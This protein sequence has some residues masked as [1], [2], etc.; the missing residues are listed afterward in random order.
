[1]SIDVSAVPDRPGGAGRYVV[2]LVRALGRRDDIDLVLVARI[3]DGGR[4][5]ALAPRAEVVAEAPVRRPA[6]L[7]WEQTALAGR[8]RRRRVDVHHGPHYTM[9]ERASLP[10]VVTIHDCT[11]F[12]H[13]EWHERSKVLVF[14]RAIR[15]AAARADALV[16]VSRVTADRVQELC[17]PRAAVH[18]V[19]HGVDHSRF[20]PAEPSPGADAARLHA[21]GLVDPYVAFVGTIEPRKDVP[22]LILAFDR[23]AGEHSGLRLVLAGGAGWGGAA[24]DVDARIAA[25]PHRDRITCT[26]YLPEEDLPALLRGAAVVA[27]PSREEGFGLPAL[28]ALAC[29][30]PVVTTAGSVMAELTAGAATVVPPGDAAAL[31]DALAAQLRS[32]ADAAAGLAVARSYTWEAT[33]DAHALVYRGLAGR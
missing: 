22:S 20:R 3:G 5:P 25:S 4:W 16:C 9:P 10:K 30:S 2:E 31:A 29:G 6:R 15:V 28:E 7:A 23:I 18:V 32:P 12:D 26:G 17:R 11:F 24:A 8:L 19:P 14:R 21:L 27:Y 33:A 13:P 1:M